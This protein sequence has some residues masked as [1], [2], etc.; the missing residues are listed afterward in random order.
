MLLQDTHEHLERYWRI[1]R[2]FFAKEDFALA[3]FF[4][5]TLIEECGK[6]VILANKKLGLELDKKGFYNHREKYIY[7]VREALLVNS[8]VS[9]IYG[10]QEEFFAKWFRDNE[11]FNIRNRS[12]YLDLD[13][14]NITT[15]HKVIK[16]E[17]AFLLVCIAGEIF[18]ELQGMFTD[19]NADEWQRVISEIDLFRSEN[20]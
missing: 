9:R 17:D 7:A 14:E 16:K 19:S 11:L 1:S 4:S 5:I 20:V 13:K 2:D 3:S 8:R 15:P 18:G 10:K 12:L 6:V